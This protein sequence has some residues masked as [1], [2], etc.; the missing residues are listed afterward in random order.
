MSA[1]L[2]DWTN[3]AYSALHFA[4]TG[5]SGTLPSAWT[6]EGPL[7]ESLHRLL[8]QQCQLSGS[9]PD[10]FARGWH[11]LTRLAIWGN[12]DLCGYHPKNG[13][14][15]RALCLD[16]TGTRIG[17]LVYAVV[18]WRAYCILRDCIYQHIKYFALLSVGGCPLVA[19]TTIATVPAASR[20]VVPPYIAVD[21]VLA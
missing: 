21:L 18:G 6:S 16:T 5:I 12:A 13:G 1:A 7:R 9:V 2:A 8:L 4:N 11:S 10:T 3:R 17:A 14:G 15:D 20:T 19:I